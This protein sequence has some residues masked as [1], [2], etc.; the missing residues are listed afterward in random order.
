MVA[1]HDIKTKKKPRTGAHA[2]LGRISFYGFTFIGIVREVLL[3]AN[4]HKLH[5]RPIKMYVLPRQKRMLIYI[6][7]ILPKPLHG[8]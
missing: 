7:I 6:G 4:N 8:F 3:L 1:Q 5:L 2:T